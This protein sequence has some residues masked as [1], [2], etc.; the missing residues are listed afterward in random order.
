M[1]RRRRRRL[2][3]RPSKGSETLTAKW[4]EDKKRPQQRHSNDNQGDCE[5]GRHASTVHGDLLTRHALLDQR[6]GGWRLPSFLGADHDLRDL[7]DYLQQLVGPVPEL[8]SELDEFPRLRDDGA[9]LRA[10]VTDAP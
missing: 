10:P 4:V 7:F 8:A 2:K 3:G 6:L 5:S 9:G 1:P